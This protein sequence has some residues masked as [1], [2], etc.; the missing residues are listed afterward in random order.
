MKIALKLDHL[1]VDY[2]EGGWPGS[3]PKDLEFFKMAK[4]VEFKNAIL[5]AFGSTRRPNGKV[6]EDAN[7][8]AFIESGA[9]VITIFGKSWDFH[10]TEALG[11]PLEENLAMI[12]E[13]IVYLK[14]N[15]KR[16]FYDAEHFFDGYKANPEYAI[17]TLL[18]AQEAG[19]ECIILCDTNGGCLPHEIVSIMDTLKKSISTPL[20]IHC[21]N[22]GDLAVA[23]SLVAVEAGAVQVQ[24]TMNGLGERCGNANLCSVIPN[25]QLKMGYDCLGESLSYLTEAARY[26]SEIA[27]LSMPTGQPFVGHSAF[28]HKGGIHV[29][30]VMKNPKTYEHL[31][32]EE[33]GN[34][35]RVLISDQSGASNL[36]YKVQELG[37]EFPDDKN[38][39]RNIIKKVKE[40]EHAGYQFE[41]AEGSFELLLKK[42]IGEFEPGFELDSFRVITQKLG[43]A[44]VNSEATIKLMVGNQVM[45]TAA[46]GNGPVN[47]LDNA[48]RKALRI[49]YPEIDQMHLADYKVRVLEGKDA[50]G[51][52]VRVLVDSKDEN[53]SWGTIGVSSDIIEASWHALTDSISYKLM[54]DKKNGNGNSKK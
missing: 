46:E 4:D 15:G 41:G 12:R 6:E 34:K 9:K 33:I 13:S 42:E 19:A 45:H 11:V 26:V 53:D 22:D 24:G 51:A 36:R 7:L 17:K 49:G 32:P 50:T 43:N 23:N 44:K 14:D 10:V 54:K 8:N 21:H 20:G 48:L 40:M 52:Q 5:A 35:R 47:A 30:A 1:G 39:Q 25:L 27:N 16:V 31:A 37:L 38:L 18:A 3:N 2:V 29:S 28:A